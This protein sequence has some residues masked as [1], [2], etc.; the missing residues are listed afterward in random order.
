MTAPAAPP[1][2]PPSSPWAPACDDP[3]SAADAGLPLYLHPLTRLGDQA[4]Q[5]LTDAFPSLPRILRLPPTHPPPRPPPRV[6]ST[7]STWP[8]SAVTPP[9]SPP[10]SS[11]RW[12]AGLRGIRLR[13]PRR[14]PASRPR[15]RAPT[16]SCATSPSPPTPHLPVGLRPRPSLPALPSPWRLRRAG[17]PPH[18][19]LEQA[20]RLHARPQCART[21][22]RPSPSTAGS[23]SASPSPS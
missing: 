16:P 17:R 19:L 1:P 6:R 21:S 13:R 5:H 4:A 12:T 14:A 11:P 15:P 18:G 7:T 23:S 10:V 20:G 3:D 22:A 9:P 8:S 2:P